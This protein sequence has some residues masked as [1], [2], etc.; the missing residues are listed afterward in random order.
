MTEYFV[1]TAPSEVEFVEKRSRFIGHVWPVDSEEGARVCIEAMKKRYHAARLHLIHRLCGKIIVY[2]E[3][4]LI[5]I[6]V[7]DLVITERDIADNHVKAVIIEICLL[8]ALDLNTLIRIELLCNS[9]ADTVQLH[10]VQL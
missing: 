1:P 7:S 6:F 10:A 2:L 4:Q 8:K 5:V 9:A 3:I